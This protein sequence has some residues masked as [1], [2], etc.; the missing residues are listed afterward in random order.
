MKRKIRTGPIL[1]NVALLVI[2]I[3]WTIPVLGD[4]AG[5]V[6]DRPGR[7]AAGDKP[8]AQ[9]IGT[10]GEAAGVFDIAEGALVL[11]NA[12]VS[13]P[14][15]G[16][17]GSGTIGLTGE[18]RLDLRIIAA[19]LGDW[20]DKVRQTNVPI[21]SDVAG[22]VFGA[23]QHLVNSATSA[24]LYEFRVTGTVADR[25]VAAVPVPVLTEPAAVLFGR[26][27]RGDKDHQLLETMR[28]GK[29]GGRREPRLGHGAGTPQRDTSSTPPSVQ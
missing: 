10:V 19:P 22:E 28:P 25:K 17:V 18:K 23:V 27:L 9:G 26:M 29:R 12:A 20:R 21:L 24:L 14:A 4:I 7:D 16:V 6:R 15:L 1:V 11:R 13:S 2:V 3:A 5:R 8:D